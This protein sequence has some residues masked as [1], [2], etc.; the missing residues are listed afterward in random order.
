MERTNGWISHHRRLARHYET[1]L[2][3]HQGFLILSQIGLLLRR[4]DK[5][6]LFDTL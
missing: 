3:A 1:T 6:Q 4:H 5:G 2:A